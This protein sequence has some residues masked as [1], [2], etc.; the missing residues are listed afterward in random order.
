VAIQAVRTAHAFISTSAW[1]GYVIEPYTDAANLTTDAQIE[2]YV[3]K[4]STTLDHPTSTA[5]I[6]KRTDKGGVVGPDL[7]VKGAHGLRVVDASI[8]VSSTVVD[9]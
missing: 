3:R 2:A 4:F 8:L 7:V 9:Y 1:A 6:S 5:K